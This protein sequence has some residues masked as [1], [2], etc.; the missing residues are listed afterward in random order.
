MSQLFVR[1]GTRPVIVA[2]SLL[3]GA[4]VYYLSRIPVRGSC[5]PDLLPGLVVMSL[6]FGAVFVGLQTAANAGVPRD[7]AGLEAHSPAQIAAFVAFAHC[8]RT[9]GFPSFPDPTSSGR[10]T[11]EMLANAWIN[12]LQPA[13]LPAADACVSVTHGVITKAIVARFVGGQ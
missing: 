5:L 8:I 1:I 11:H 10:L 2:G 3:A 12:L 4:G 13:V 6:G 9:H 7:K